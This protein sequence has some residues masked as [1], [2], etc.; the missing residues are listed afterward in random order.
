MSDAITCFC[1]VRVTFEVIQL[2]TGDNNHTQE[3]SLGQKKKITPLLSKWKENLMHDFSR[4][5]R[6]ES[7]FSTSFHFHVQR[8]QLIQISPVSVCVV[9]EMLVHPFNV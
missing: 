9:L 3:T 2:R 7:N 6:V 5:S 1:N 8:E 4:E